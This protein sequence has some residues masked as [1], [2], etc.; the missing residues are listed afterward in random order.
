RKNARHRASGPRAE[1]SRFDEIRAAM[2]QRVRGVSYAM[3]CRGAPGTATLDACIP[4]TGDGNGLPAFIGC[5]CRPPSQQAGEDLGR[6]P[7]TTTDQRPARWT[8]LVSL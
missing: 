4:Q 5:G 2:G 8:L 3:A 7:K 6:A 1:K